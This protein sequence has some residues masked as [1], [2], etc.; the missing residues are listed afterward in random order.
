MVFIKE[1]HGQ[2]RKLFGLITLKAFINFIRLTNITQKKEIWI[3][4]TILPIF[5][6]FLFIF[7]ITYTFI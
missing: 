3:K 1:L 4:F 6:Y 7:N 5:N 2:E